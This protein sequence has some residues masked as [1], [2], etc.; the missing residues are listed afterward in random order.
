L[1]LLLTL[2]DHLVAPARPSRRQVTDCFYGGS[3][4]VAADERLRITRPYAR[5]ARD[6]MRGVLRDRMIRAGA[7]RVQVSIHPQ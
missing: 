1:S 5:V 4:G 2:V 3:H 6:R 7:V